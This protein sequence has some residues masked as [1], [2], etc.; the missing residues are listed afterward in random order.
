MTDD[1]LVMDILTRYSKVLDNLEKIKT[2][3]NDLFSNMLSLGLDVL[4]LTK[5]KMLEN[6]SNKFIE[7]I[8]SIRSLLSFNYRINKDEFKED[9]TYLYKKYVEDN[10]IFDSKK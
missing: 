4:P 3:R 6:V 7:E 1:E 10:K 9:L 8:E 5:L 2:L